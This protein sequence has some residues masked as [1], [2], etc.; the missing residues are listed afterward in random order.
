VLSQK[1]LRPTQTPAAP[2]GGERGAASEAD[3][4]R[5]A[6][7]LAALA[8]G[9][10][11]VAGTLRHEGWLEFVRSLLDARALFLLP[12]EAAEKPMLAIA[13]SSGLS[14]EQIVAEVK[15]V[16]GR[17]V[18]PV[19]QPCLLAGAHGYLFLI[20]LTQLGRPLYHFG[21][22]VRVP[23][24]HDLNGLFLLLQAL[25]GYVLYAEGQGAATR[26]L[27]V[28]TQMG[29]LLDLFRRAASELDERRA[30][31]MAVDEVREYLGC[32]RVVLG[33]KRRRRLQLAA[34]SGAERIEATSPAHHAIEV[35]Q[36]EAIATGNPI[37]YLASAPPNAET[38]AH[39]L[40]AA[41]TRMPRLLTLPLPQERGAVTL[42]WAR[43]ALSPGEERLA[44]VGRQ[45]VPLLFDL[46]ERAKPNPLLFGARR[47]WRK[48]GGNGRNAA[49]LSGAALAGLLAFPFPYKIKADCRLVPKTQRALAAPFD[50]TLRQST[51]RP[52]DRVKK[53]DILAEMEPRDLKMK[54]AELVASRE[55]ALRQRDRALRNEGEGTDFSEAQ[56]AD[57][58]ALGLGEELALVQRRIGQLTLAAPLDG[59]IVAGDLRR[60]EGQPI[61]Q[62]QVLF[63]VAPLDELIVEIDIPDSEVRHV[64]P[65]QPVEYRIDAIAGTEWNSRL[66]RVHPQ[67]E[68]REA[69]NVFVGEAAAEKATD[70]NTELRPG[71]RGRASITTDRRALIWILGHRLWDWLILRLFW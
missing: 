7:Q 27:W 55:K 34:I 13:S 3:A 30:R 57:Y 68:Q 48:L 25:S 21:A 47:F 15:T 69:R 65:R 54:E 44:E 60:A 42:Q 8:E 17:R 56:L 9:S 38:L 61:A 62:G 28:M 24:A 39:E 18:A 2:S 16:L 19:V 4:H 41:E 43:E 11:S 35:A 6:G 64:R 37:E 1:E 59:V 12:A 36:A 29:R 10:A 5:L 71:M 33:L 63:E 23:Q 52:G 53:G 58:E 31:Q 49:V 67:S 50:A 26:D 20:E 32:D 51:A 14:A 45:F 40:L 46:L 66:D 70:A 22:L